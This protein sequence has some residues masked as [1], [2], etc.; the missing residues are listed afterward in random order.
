MHNGKYQCHMA[1]SCTYHLSS[2]SCSK[3]IWAFSGEKK[4]H[5]NGP[6]AEKWQDRQSKRT[7]HVKGAWC[8]E[9]M[10]CMWTVCD[11][12]DMMYVWKCMRSWIYDVK[13]GF[14]PY[15]PLLVYY[16]CLLLEKGVSSTENCSYCVLWISTELTFCNQHTPCSNLSSDWSF[17]KNDDDILAFE[18]CTM[19]QPWTSHTPT[20]SHSH[21][22]SVLVQKHIS[23]ITVLQQITPEVKPN[24]TELKGIL[25]TYIV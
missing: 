18:S 20:C 24:L 23:K 9:Y 11:L 3:N 5:K 12:L 17:A 6:L 7:R 19:A 15:H 22:F 4:S 2:P 25:Q 13:I 10:T 21:W 16:V 14:H 8:N 1:A